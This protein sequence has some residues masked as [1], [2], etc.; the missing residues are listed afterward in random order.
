[1][2]Q[3]ESTNRFAK[4]SSFVIYEVL[5]S[6]R[7]QEI[8]KREAF[9]ALIGRT[10]NGGHALDCEALDMIAANPSLSFLADL[11]QVARNAL[12]ET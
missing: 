11:V 6:A 8:D 12:T 4:R 9:A 5:Q 7:A 1:M 10:E 3:S 2:S